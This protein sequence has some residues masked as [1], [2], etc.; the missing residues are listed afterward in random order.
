M[1]I[2]ILVA[3]A[4]WPVAAQDPVAQPFDFDHMITTGFWQRLYP[5]GGY[6][7]LCGEHFNGARLTAD[8]QAVI[9]DLIFPLADMLKS[10]GCRDRAECRARHGDKF[11]RMESDLHNMYPEVRELVT[12]RIGRAYGTVEGE[13]SRIDDCDVEWRNGAFEPRELA[14]G[15]IARAILYMRATHGLA[16]SDPML[17]MMKEWHREDPPSKQELERNSAIAE[18]QGRRNLFVDRPEVVEN[19]HN[20]K[21]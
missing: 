12:Q 14:R 18:L 1:L 17:D 19:L 2:A 10:L 21:R 15:N 8:G 5:A 16:I 3:G 4:T 9:V 11:A 7:L 20:L 13:D 6:T